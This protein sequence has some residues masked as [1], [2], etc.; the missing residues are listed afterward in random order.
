[1]KQGDKKSLLNRI[2]PSMKDLQELKA[3][4]CP[5]TV[6]MPKQFFGLILYFYRQ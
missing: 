6:R 1:M 3:T 2:L 5:K 4:K